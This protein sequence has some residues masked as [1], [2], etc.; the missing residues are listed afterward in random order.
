MC[1]VALVNSV[2]VSSV[3]ADRTDTQVLTEVNNAC[4]H[5]G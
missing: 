4:G 5:G 3:D 1:V 2:V